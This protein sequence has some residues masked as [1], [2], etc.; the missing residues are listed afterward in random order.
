MNKICT[1][2]GEDKPLSEFSKDKNRHDGYKYNCKVCFKLQRNQIACNDYQSARRLQ[3]KQFLI[4]YLGNSCIVCGYDRD[5]KALELHHVLPK[6]FSLSGPHLSKRTAQEIEKEADK[7]ITLCS[8]C[9]R[10]LHSGSILS[11]LT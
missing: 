9:H 11:I 1:K 5:Y 6:S 10:E 4:D 3:Q 7:C 2:C 8:C